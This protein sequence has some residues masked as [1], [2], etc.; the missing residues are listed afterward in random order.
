M[1]A[2]RIQQARDSLVRAGMAP[3]HTRTSR[4]RIAENRKQQGTRIEGRNDLEPQVGSALESVTVM[5]SRADGVF[6]S[7]RRED[8][9]HIAGRLADRLVDQFGAE[10][11]FMDVDSIEP[12]TDFVEAIEL[13]LSRSKVL[14]LMIGPSWVDV[15]DEQGDRRID[16]PND[17]VVLEIRAAL[18]R[19]IRVIPVLTDSARLPRRDE[20]PP[21]LQ[22]LARRNAIRLDHESFRSDVTQLIAV[23]GSIVPIPHGTPTVGTEDQEPLP[24]PLEE[25]VKDEP[26]EPGPHGGNTEAASEREHRLDRVARQDW[27]ARLLDEGKGKWTVL[28]S[29]T[30]EEHEI[31]RSQRDV[32]LLRDDLFADG[33]KFASNALPRNWDASVS[34]SD[35]PHSRMLRVAVYNWRGFVEISVDDRQ[36]LAFKWT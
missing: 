1:E 25:P 15:V 32:V 21:G 28:V 13:A 4:V 9:Q 31:R 36:L 3:L 7:Y 10:Q 18:E 35:G 17:F 19:G 23:V 29:L 8:T 27:S 34:L 24:P 26:N 16:D 2:P 12:G 6:L 20:L 11:V 5:S 30:F 33:T 14:I 22:L